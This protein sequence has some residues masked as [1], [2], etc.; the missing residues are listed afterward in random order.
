MTVSD[1]STSRPGSVRLRREPPPLQPVT[2]A[3]RHEL[4]PRLLRFRFEGPGLRELAEADPAASVR[5]LVPS[6][7]VR[8][9]VMP[10]W[11]GNE[12]LLPD[13]SRP[14]LR[15]F[16]PLRIDRQAGALDLEIVRHPG[17]AVSTWAEAAEPGAE[18]AISGP[19]KGYAVDADASRFI[20][21][22]DET[23]IP[24]ISDLLEALPAH[25]SV[26][27]HV[28]VE[29]ATAEVPMPSHPG[30]S[31]DWHLRKAGAAPGTALVEVAG[32]LDRLDESSRLWAAGEAASMQGI[33]NHLFKVL[34][35]PRNQT[36]IR[37]Y[38]K[39]PRRRAV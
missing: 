21:L 14:A 4:S 22:G 38:W 3:A 25:A 26:D 15:T 1:P 2:V 33:R 37:G 24:A 6:S 28:E 12:F 11:N 7:A 13:G 5:L 23:A 39:P 9:L 36:S 29:T 27:V 35:V 17:G 18:A 32:R 20:L 8:K 10:E 19:G 34:A 16:T 31:L 30:R